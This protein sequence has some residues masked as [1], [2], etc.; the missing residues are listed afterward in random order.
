MLSTELSNGQL[1]ISTPSNMDSCESATIAWQWSGSQSDLSDNTVSI[2]V[3]EESSSH[4]RS[5]AEPSPIRFIRKRSGSNRRLHSRDSNAIN[6]AGGQQVPMSDLEWIWNSVGVPQGTYRMVLTID[7]QGYTAYSDP[8]TVSLGSDTSCLGSLVSTSSGQNVPTTTAS[9]VQTSTAP[10]MVTTAFNS[11]STASNQASQGV[12]K[13]SNPS[14]STSSSIAPTYSVQNTSSSQDSKKGTSGGG[15]AAGVIIPLLVVGGLL[16][17]FCFRRKKAASGN[18]PSHDWSEK[19]TGFLGGSRNNYNNNSAHRREISTPMD[20]VHAAGLAMHEHAVKTQMRQ[21]GEDSNA[22]THAPEH[23]VDFGQDIQESDARLVTPQRVDEMI[24]ASMDTAR[25]EPFY[26][27]GANTDLRQSTANS[28]QRSTMMTADSDGNSTLPS[29]LRDADF[30]SQHTHS[31]FGHEANGTAV[32][33][34]GD[35]APLQRSPTQKS[36]LERKDSKIRR[37]PV[38]TYSTIGVTQAAAAS[39]STLHSDDVSPFSDAHRVSTPPACEFIGGGHDSI[40]TTS[41]TV[42]QDEKLQ[43][44]LTQDQEVMEDSPTLPFAET[45]IHSSTDRFPVSVYSSVAG[46]PPQRILLDT[47]RRNSLTEEQKK[48]SYKLSIQLPQEDRGFRVSF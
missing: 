22:V 40:A 27:Q 6:I 29:Y 48:E 42:I 4:R 46:S 24:R 28:D 18:T 30:A 41:T 31:S 14:S 12:S 35:D 16:Y 2:A 34:V 45:P 13:T 33:H 21:A 11:T 5:L 7:N 32:P 44:M 3:E 38:P 9:S 1:D 37:K 23:W 39:S 19:F 25:N 36:A 17:Y 8:F 43:E 10:G 47:P 15:I 20:P 26:Q